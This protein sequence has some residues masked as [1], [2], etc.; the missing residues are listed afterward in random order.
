MKSIGSQIARK[1]LLNGTLAAC[2]TLIVC[3]CKVIFHL[4]NSYIWGAFYLFIAAAISKL[5]HGGFETF[6]SFVIGALILA[7]GAI[8]AF[9]WALGVFV[10]GQL[11]LMWSN[12]V[13]AMPAYQKSAFEHENGA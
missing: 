12:K 11:L 5:F 6:F 1:I 8:W 4:E 9:N 13:V 3:F 7:A 10:F 2:C